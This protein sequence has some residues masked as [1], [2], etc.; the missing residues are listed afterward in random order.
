MLSNTHAPSFV[1]S[2]EN[3][4]KYFIKTFCDPKQADSNDWSKHMA[5]AELLTSMKFNEGNKE[6]VQIEHLE[7]N[8]ETKK[9]KAKK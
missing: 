6:E 1:K 5:M 4:I 8:G 2:S 3:T 9:K 7:S